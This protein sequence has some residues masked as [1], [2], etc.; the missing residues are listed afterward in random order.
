[1]N[2]LAARVAVDGRDGSYFGISRA[3]SNKWWPDQGEWT[4]MAACGEATV[5]ERPRL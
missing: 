1:M 3:L 5:V 4:P 2:L